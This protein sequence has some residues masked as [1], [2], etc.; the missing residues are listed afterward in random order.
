MLQC[1]L[2]QE[3]KLFWFRRKLGCLHAVYNVRKIVNDNTAGSDGQYTLT[4][5]V[6]GLLHD[7]FQYSLC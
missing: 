4:R 3:R 6:K 2:V 1:E 7:E 5:P